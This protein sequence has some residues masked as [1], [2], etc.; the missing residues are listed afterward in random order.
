MQKTILLACIAAGSALAAGKP[1]DKR[2]NNAAA[3]FREI[4][5]TP[6]RSIPQDLLQRAACIVIIPGLKKGAFGFGGK[7]GRGFASCR[8]G[9]GGWG[10]PAGI[11][12]EGGSFGFQLG[13]SS[14]DVVMLV[15]NERGMGRLLSDKFTLGGEASAAAGPVGRNADRKSVV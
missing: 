9:G 12:I 3:V 2:L 13:G 11:R 10:S 8:L 4:M 14:T 1:E 15:M 6:D 5:K 7:Y